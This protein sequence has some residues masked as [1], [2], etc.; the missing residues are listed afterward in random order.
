MTIR[1]LL[2]DD[3]A[4]LRE[5]LRK[6]LEQQNNVKVV[7]EA[8]DGKSAVELARK[9]KPQIV[10]M[11]IG[12]PDMNGFVATETIKSEFPAVKII[13]LSMHSDKQYVAKMIYAGSSAYLRKDCVSEEI[14]KA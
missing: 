11:D 9:H 2:A 3:H 10:I 12:M 6:L 5:G 13:A 1:V 7:A 4:I 8:T 14:H